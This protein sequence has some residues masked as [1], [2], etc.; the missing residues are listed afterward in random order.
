MSR[1]RAFLIVE[2]R[3]IDPS[4]FGA[5]AGADPRLGDGTYEVYV[6][7]QISGLRHT[8]GK[9]GVIEFHDYLR[10]RQMLSQENRVTKVSVLC[11][12]DRDFDHVLGRV[13]RR[14]PH[15]VYTKN[16]NVE[17]EVF[18]VADSVRAMSGALSL[19]RIEAEALVTAL[20]DWQEQLGEL[21]SDWIELCILD[22]GLQAGTGAAPSRKSAVN[23]GTYGR[24]D[25]AGIASALQ[26]I[27]VRSRVQNAIDRE[28]YLRARF[29]NVTRS[30]GF[31][32]VVNG[33]HFPSYFEH[34][35]K[36]YYTDDPIALT[37]LSSRLLSCFLMAV[38]F[39]APWSSHYGRQFSRALAAR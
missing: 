12:V 8:R 30:D 39:T 25:A 19:T 21:W 31:A 2:G 1:K 11:C 36:G 16:Y 33:K 34:R 35:V 29:R 7:D 18:M 4:F 22:A 14:S 17:A 10:R 26:T 13:R 23:A 6:I 37:G 9:A 24:V 15:L 38:D 5:L 27:R 3:E 28:R 32:S 20:G